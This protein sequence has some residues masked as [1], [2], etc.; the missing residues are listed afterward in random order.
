ME[1]CTAS[2]LIFMVITTD[3][4]AEWDDPEQGLVNNTDVAREQA[5]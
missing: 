1:H 2:P 3:L 4:T 5:V